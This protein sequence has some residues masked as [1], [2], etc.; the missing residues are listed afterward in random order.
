MISSTKYNNK[1]QTYCTAT[2]QCKTLK[3]TVCQ[4]TKLQ[5]QYSNN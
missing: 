5:S 2:E 3:Y 4:I 1:K